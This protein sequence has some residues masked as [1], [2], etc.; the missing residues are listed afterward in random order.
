[1]RLL[2]LLLAGCFVYAMLMAGAGV[3]FYLKLPAWAAAAA[4]VLLAAIA[5]TLVFYLSG[6]RRAAFGQ[7]RG[8]EEIAT[9]LRDQ[10]LL[11]SASFKAARAF[12]VEEFE[13]E[14][15]HYFLELR[16]NAGV[17]FL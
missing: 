8:A 13:D 7:N 4:G 14:G 16:S 5:A 10:G 2:K 15:L 17:L 11:E 12:Q 1:M 6:G 9:E 3:G